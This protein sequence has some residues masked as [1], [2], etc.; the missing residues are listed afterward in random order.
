L[1]KILLILIAGCIFSELAS[2]SI[3]VVLDGTPVFNGADYTWTYAADLQAGEEIGDS[4][5]SYFTIYDFVGLDSV[6]SVPT[7]WTYSEQFTGVTPSGVLPSDNPG[8]ENITF[9]YIGA[10]I[11]GSQSL[12]DFV[13][14]SADGALNTNGNFSFQTGSNEIETKFQAPG[15]PVDQGLG[16]VTVPTAITPEPK[17]GLLMALGAGLLGLAAKRRRFATRIL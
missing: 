5:L 4:I 14:T 16:K 8:I 1:K 17:L 2:A 3:S 6:V 12:G 15:D 9:D 13:L 7:G 11:D 10:E